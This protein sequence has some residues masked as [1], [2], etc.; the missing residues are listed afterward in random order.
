MLLSSVMH[1]VI[2]PHR[3]SGPKRETVQFCIKEKP[4]SLKMSQENLM[5]RN[6]NVGHGTMSPKIWKHM[7]NSLFIVSIDGTPS[8]NLK[9]DKMVQCKNESNII[10]HG[11]G[12]LSPQ[13]A[14]I[15]SVKVLVADNVYVI[16]AWNKS[17]AGRYQCMAWNGIM[18]NE[19]LNCSIDVH[20]KLIDYLEFNS[21][22]SFCTHT[23]MNVKLL[24]VYI[25]TLIFFIWFCS[26]S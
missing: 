2:H 20:C 26:V 18:R 10:M 1:Q 19:T 17:Q 16:R 5:D 24:Q 6:T 21:R 25:Q 4:L 11:T 23:W 22:I 13:T 14:W 12:N 3:L 7:L 9:L 8:K 15:K